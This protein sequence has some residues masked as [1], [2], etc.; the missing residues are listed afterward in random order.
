MRMDQ[1]L[2][3]QGVSVLVKPIRVKVEPVRVEP[4]E[5]CRVCIT[6]LIILAIFLFILGLPVLKVLLTGKV[7]H[8]Y[9]DGVSFN[10]T[11]NVVTK[12]FFK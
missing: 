9:K 3:K 12:K 10:C 2:L 1:A 11:N 7:L 4:V 5:K 6:V 8:K